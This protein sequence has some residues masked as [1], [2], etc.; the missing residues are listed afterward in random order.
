MISPVWEDFKGVCTLD[1]SSRRPDTM[2]VID[3]LVF[4]VYILAYGAMGSVLGLSGMLWVRRREVRFLKTFLFL[5]YLTALLFFSGLRYGLQAFVGWNGPVAFLVFE[6]LERIA[7]ASLIYFLPATINYILGR[8]WTRKRLSQVIAAAGFYLTAGTLS[9]LTAG[10]L[11]TGGLAVVAFLL[12]VFFVL[13][14]ASRS[15]PMVRDERMRIALFLLY[16][17]TFLILPL[18]QILPYVAL[19]Y[20]EIR[21]LAVSLYYLSIGITADIFFLRMFS[22]SHVSGDDDGSVFS[23]SC[24][25]SGLTPREIQIAGLIAQGLTYK[26]IAAELDISPN[27]VSNHVATIYRKTGTRS[28]VEMVNALR[29]T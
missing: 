28:K 6:I 14:D 29:G 9:L 23:E 4:A 12:I 19:G 5:A 13:V 21:F 8:S 25:K 2:F 7:F 24:A 17:L 20:E 22:D 16:G 15:L 18:T 11:I 27:T 10:S 26:E 1:A 3:I